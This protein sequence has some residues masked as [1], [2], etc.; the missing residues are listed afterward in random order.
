MTKKEKIRFFIACVLSVLFIVYS[1]FI[2]SA[3]YDAIF[4]Q[5]PLSTE[6]IF[7]TALFGMMKLTVL[8]FGIGVLSMGGLAAFFAF[9]FRNHSKKN[10]K[11]PM[12]SIFISNICFIVLDALSLFILLL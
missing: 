10:V 9:S 5:A 7:G 4:R 11:A 8:I 6:N 12:K 1:V 2:V 3:A